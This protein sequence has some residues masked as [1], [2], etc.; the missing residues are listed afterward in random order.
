[1]NTNT[2]WTCGNVAVSATL[3]F[4]D[5]TPRWIANLATS[6]LT[7]ELQ[8]T[9]SSTWEKA[10][11]GYEKRPDK[12][13]RDSIPYGEESAAALAEL[14]DKHCEAFE[15]GPIRVN[16]S[17]SEHVKGT[18]TSP[19]VRATK[20]VNDLVT[21]GSEALLRQLFLMQGL[22]NAVVATTE[23]LITFA[24]SKKMGQG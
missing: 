8:R 24:H 9:P 16:F 7:Q 14:F 4:P 15:G 18:E 2:S 17:T 6:G 22:E 3:E 13:R 20:F 11:A 12:F 10:E 1:M 5:T 21:S 19:M 23:E